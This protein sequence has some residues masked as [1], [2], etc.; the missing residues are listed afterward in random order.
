[1]FT[2]DLT[3]YNFSVTDTKF[4][5]WSRLGGVVGSK[6]AVEEF[7]PS[8]EVPLKQVFA[9]DIPSL[10]QKEPIGHRKGILIPVTGQNE[11]TGHFVLVID[12]A[13]QKYPIE[14]LACV[15]G[16]KQK[17]PARHC[18]STEDIEGQ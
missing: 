7:A 5:E 4:P 2:M 14:Q 16:V 12:P 11:P 17:Y 8:N 18:V 3:T 9:A 13:G 1:M 15:F 10:S 6:Q